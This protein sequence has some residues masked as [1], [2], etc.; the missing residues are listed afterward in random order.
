MP[1]PICIFVFNRP[2]ATLNLLDSLSCNAEAQHSELYIFSDAARN[3]REYP[4]VDEVRQII[5]NESRF[6]TI[7]IEESPQNKGLASSIIEGVTSVLQKHES[8]IVLEDD[9]EVASNFLTFMNDA[10]HSYKDRSDIWS[11]SGY[12]PTI[13]IPPDYLDEVF[14]VPRAQSWGWATWSNRWHKVDWEVKQFNIL[15]D[16]HQR[17]LFNQGG[18][19]L[20]RTLDMQQH[21]KIESWAIRF[22]F[23]GFFNHA[24]TVNPIYSKVRNQAAG[25]TTN[26]QG[27]NDQRHQVELSSH[28]INLNP[29]IQ[30]N[31]SLISAFK[32]HHDLGLISSIG[33]F[34][35][36]HGIGYHF[37]KNL[38]KHK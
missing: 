23:A 2:Q 21:G 6:K 3:E 5:R 15:K 7:Y 26:H 32:Q 31:A 19:D 20:Y 22:V 24:Y 33:Y 17:A 13:S 9:L 18:N 14:L 36:R 28:P 38:L 35:R 29:T 10:L 12:T 25:S 4:K 1:A 37:I 8:V 30:P 34:M 16:K 27:W 11:I